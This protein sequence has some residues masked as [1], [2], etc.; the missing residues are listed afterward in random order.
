MIVPALPSQHFKTYEIIAPLSTH[1]RPATCEEVE[2]EAWRNGWR[3]IAPMSSEAAQYIKSGASGRRFEETTS[4]DSTMAEF[5]FAPG[6]KCF[7]ADR[8][9]VPLEREPLYVARGGDARGNP[10]RERRV[11]TRASDWQEDF[12]GHLDRVRQSKGE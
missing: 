5:L 1:F 2:C 6:Q 4:I 7:A 11:H 9:R 3:T 12:A 10:M 8:H